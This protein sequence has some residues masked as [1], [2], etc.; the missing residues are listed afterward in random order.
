MKIFKEMFVAS[1]KDMVRDRAS[2]FWFFAFPLIFIFIFGIV[3]S[4]GGDINYYVGVVNESN[5]PIIAKIVEGINSVP[6]FNVTTGTKEEELKAIKEGHRN[7]VL[8]I[9]DISVQDLYKGETIDI[10]LYVDGSDT[11]NNQILTSIFDKVF[12]GIENNI[13][14]KSRLFNIKQ[15]PIQSKQLSNFDYILP[16]ILAMSIMQLGLFGSLRFLS[17]KE[18][19]IVRGLAVTPLPRNIIIS[20]EFLLRLLMSMVQTF[21]ILFIGQGVFGV[22]IIGSVFKVAGIV[23]LG[24]LTFISMGYLLIS[25]AKTQ[26]SGNGII[27]AIQFPMMFLSGTF[28]PIAIMPDYIKPVVRALPLTYLGDALRQVMI[29]ATPMFSLSTDLLVLV[30]WLVGCTILAIKFWKWE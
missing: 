19:K 8:I 15:Q 7:T 21:L 23:I 4:G 3:F 27:Q 10:P 22:T 13:T 29:G 16:G 20:S 18:Q 5:D 14:G 11:T 25:F 24:A 9:P 12:V 26:E 1:V 2:L 30:A 17:L 28:F 6:A